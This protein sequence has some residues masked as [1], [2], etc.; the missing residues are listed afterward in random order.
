M[1][2]RTPSNGSGSS[3]NRSSRGGASGRPACSF[4]RHCFRVRGTRRRPGVWRGRAAI[5]H[6]PDGYF[7]RCFSRCR[8]ARPSERRSQAVGPTNPAPCRSDWRSG[9]PCGRTAVRIDQSAVLLTQ[10]SGRLARHACG[11]GLRSRSLE[12]GHRLLP[13][14]RSRSRTSLSKKRQCRGYRCPGRT[15]V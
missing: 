6:R 1:Q 14:H 10:A 15:G 8:T 11:V 4:P 5:R 9:C 3:G 2:A 13:G 7:H 12:G